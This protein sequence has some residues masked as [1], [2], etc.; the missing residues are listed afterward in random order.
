MT[1]KYRFLA[2]ISVAVFATACAPEQPDVSSDDA[3]APATDPD[4][5]MKEREM[6][7]SVSDLTMRGIF[8]IDV[9]VSRQHVG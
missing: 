6:Y 2:T 4:Q 7:G 1:S 8:Q 5:A 3:D 9:R